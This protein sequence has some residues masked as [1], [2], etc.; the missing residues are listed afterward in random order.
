L[1]PAARDD[2]AAIAAIQASSPE[3]A[4]WDPASYLEHDCT[5]AIAD[6]VVAGFLV[7]REIAAGEREILNLA[8][9]PSQRCRGVAR[10][11]LES[12]L[13]R[14]RGEWFLEVRESNAGARRFYESLGFRVTGQRKDYYR[15][16][17]EGAIVMRFFS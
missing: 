6:G 2:L 13:A 4:Q 12:E 3:A 14:A 10:C 5:V 15:E 16:P 11:L 8:V 9:D 17:P 1:R 7:S